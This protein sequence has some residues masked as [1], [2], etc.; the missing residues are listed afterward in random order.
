V[1]KNKNKLA[2]FKG[3]KLFHELD[4]KN[5]E[6]KFVKTKSYF[7]FEFLNLFGPPAGGWCLEF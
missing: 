5:H 3:L 2:L 1:D 7:G 4:P 6:E